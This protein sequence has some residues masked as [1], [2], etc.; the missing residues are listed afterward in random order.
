[1][2]ESPILYKRTYNDGK[3]LPEPIWG[4]PAG[5]LQCPTCASIDMHAS[6]S[7]DDPTELAGTETVRCF[8]CGHITD[9]FEAWKARRDHHTDT[10]REIV[11]ELP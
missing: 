10:P 7:S 6:A 2:G 11:Y 4:P 1:M 9:Y 5:G 8:D 3:N